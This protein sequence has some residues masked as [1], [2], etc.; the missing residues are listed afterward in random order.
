MP[1]VGGGVVGDGAVG[2]GVDGDDAGG[3]GARGAWRPW[4]MAFVGV[5]RSNAVVAEGLANTQP[6]AAH[7]SA[8]LGLQL[9]RCALTTKS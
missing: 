6:S 2:D 3:D 7:C 4:G 5:L 1:S 9:N 8:V